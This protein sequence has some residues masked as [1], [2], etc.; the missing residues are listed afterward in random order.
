[1]HHRTAQRP[2]K[3]ELQ[4]SNPNGWLTWLAHRTVSGGAPDC[5][6]R[7][8][9]AVFQ[10]PYFGGWGY[11]YPN[12][13]IF[14]SIQ[15][16]H[17]QHITRAIAFK[18]REQKTTQGT[19]VWR[20]GPSGVP[21]DRVWCTTGQ[22]PVHQGTQ[23]WTRYLRENQRALRYNSPD[24]PVPHRTVQCHT[25][26]SGV[27][28]EQRLLRAQRSSTTALIALQCVPESEHAQLA[29]QTVYRT[30]PVH[31]RTAQRPH[32]SDL[33]QSNPNGWLTWLAH[34]TVSG[35]APH[36]PVRHATTH[37]QRP[38][39]VVGAINTPTTPH[40]MASKFLH[41]YTLQEL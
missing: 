4:R 37:F 22:C 15:V 17:L 21:P 36:C 28:A 33:Q 30:C 29:H 34:Q 12:H 35:G 5:P 41:F 23:R 11:K 14:N 3:S 2:H 1:V 13:P 6:V 32:K 25:G 10:Q 26:L 27:P 39:L 38:F 20:T 31:H 18:Q 40:S 16:F 8:A 7:H 19:L 24:C 9:T